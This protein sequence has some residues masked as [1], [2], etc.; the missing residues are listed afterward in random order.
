[1]PHLGKKGLADSELFSQG[2]W[3][4]ASAAKRAAASLRRENKENKGVEDA[5]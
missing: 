2:L 3:P 5:L 1:M 4:G